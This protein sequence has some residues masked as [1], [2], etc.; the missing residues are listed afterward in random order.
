[1]PQGNRNEATESPILQAGINQIYDVK[2]SSRN[3][4]F[5]IAIAGSSNAIS[6]AKFDSSRGST[7]AFVV[8]KIYTVDAALGTLGSVRFADVDGTGYPALILGI[9]ANGVATTAIMRG[10]ADGTFQPAVALP[11][12]H[13]TLYEYDA[14]GH[15]TK[16]T[17]P[18]GL[19]TAYAYSGGKL[20]SA[21]DPAGK[22]TQFALVDG[23]LQAITRADGT[24]L[25]YAYDASGH[26]TAETDPLGATT[27]NTFNAAGQVTKATFP[28]GASVKLDLAKSLG[29]ADLSGPT[30]IPQ[31]Y[32]RPEDRVTRMTDARGKVTTVQ[33]NEW[34]G[35][36][37]QLDPLG[38]LTTY[39]RTPANLVS[40]IDAPSSVAPP[41]AAGAFSGYAPLTMGLGITQ[42]V[43]RF[44]DKRLNLVIK[45]AI[46]DPLAPDPAAGAVGTT[47]TY[48]AVGNV[49]EVRKAVG[50]LQ[51]TKTQYEYEPVHNHI[52]K[53][54]EWPYLNISQFQ[55]PLTVTTYVYDAN[56]NLISSTEI[57]DLPSGTT[58]PTKTATYNA[59]GLKLTDTD[60][61]GHTSTMTYD[62]KGNLASMTNA[63]GVI[64]GIARDGNGNVTAQTDAV[65][66]A[67]ERTTAMTYDPLNRQTS[68]TDGEGN[69]TTYQYDFYG[70][71][72][73]ITDPTGIVSTSTYDIRHPL[74]ANGTVY[75][76][77]RDTDSIDVTLTDV[78]GLID[79]NA[80]SLELLA[81]VLAGIGVP[82][83]H[84]QT[85]ASAIVDFRD[86]DDDPLPGGAEAK[87]YRA[88]GRTYG[89]KNAPFESVE[90]L[91]QV[92]G[93][94]PDILARLRG[95]VTVYSRAPVLDIQLAP[96][97]LVT[98]LSR[99][100]P[101]AKSP[102]DATVESLRTRLADQFL[103][104]AGPRSR[105]HTVT[106]GVTTASG[107]CFRRCTVV[108]LS[109]NLQIGFVLHEWKAVADIGGVSTASIPAVPCAS[110]IF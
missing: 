34:G 101:D 98:A 77:S 48:D 10:N 17:D 72:V 54:T 56:G 78:A 25:K 3:G 47:M 83:L 93:M 110:P 55:Y 106:V 6:I 108:E 38:R 92:L 40:R 2:S 94:T 87:E 81:R 70:N 28:D 82:Q 11:V 60:E 46:S 27:T 26:L 99:A 88:A 65:G 32:I 75:R 109:D 45:A 36:L 103:S 19:V 1:M 84:A 43:A 61:L 13:G 12:G 59:Q 73:A 64:T 66:T 50:T 31:N 18:A 35:V 8:P 24:A 71:V 30:P 105:I 23:N 33:L 100:L 51:E 80:G 96:P 5:D 53:K 7:G 15:L 49:T 44:L 91:D 85:L 14:A 9:A 102:A 107:G 76:C 58:G 67:V 63:N 20:A 95:L 79:L 41:P 90:E 69:R 68:V 97:A 104:T 4:R 16:Q 37:R 57:T 86:I 29:L 74:L 62:A 52:T 21:T 22:V 39:I 89:P 42:N